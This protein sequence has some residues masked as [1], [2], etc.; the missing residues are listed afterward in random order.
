MFTP[1]NMINK[2]KKGEKKNCIPYTYLLFAVAVGL[3]LCL[4]N[5][6]PYTYLLFAVAVEL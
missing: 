6:V 5:C 3:E 4:T 2:R 1:V